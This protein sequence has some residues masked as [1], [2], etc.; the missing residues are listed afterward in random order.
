MKRL[1]RHWQL[2]NR[3]FY[4]LCC[5][6]EINYGV[7]WVTINLKPA[8][9]LSIGVGKTSWMHLKSHRT[10]WIPTE[11]LC[12]TTGYHKETPWISRKLQKVKL[13]KE[14][15]E[16]KSRIFGFSWSNVYND[17]S[18]EG[19]AI[20][21][22]YICITE[23]WFLKNVS[24]VFSQCAASLPR[25]VTQTKSLL[26]NSIVSLFMQ[27]NNV[28]PHHKVFVL[29]LLSPSCAATNPARIFFVISFI[30]FYF[31]TLLVKRHPLNRSVNSRKTHH[32]CE[33]SFTFC[34]NEGDHIASVTFWMTPHKRTQVCV[35][36]FVCQSPI[37]SLNQPSSITQT[38]VHV[39]VS[40]NFARRVPGT[41][42]G[43]TAE[44]LSGLWTEKSG[45]RASLSGFDCVHAFYFFALYLFFLFFSFHFS[46]SRWIFL[47]FF[48]WRTIPLLTYQVVLLLAEQSWCTQGQIAMAVGSNNSR[49]CGERLFFFSFQSLSLSVCADEWMNTQK[50]LPR[51]RFP[52]TS[53]AVQN[54]SSCSG[55][56]H[57]CVFKILECGSF[58]GRKKCNRGF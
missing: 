5:S 39:V 47:C 42:S 15:Y 35:C 23:G 44:K 53:L 8:Q 40:V 29:C 36:V 43:A 50:L 55:E 17:A 54:I 7:L 31:V 20:M 28:F 27:K 11:Q 41:N 49:V 32:G 58:E 52:L 25:N 51:W 46:A 30:S 4:S 16:Y 13:F 1:N 34:S 33:N 21:S 45:P 14:S 38:V 10:R 6:I 24:L 48:L 3:I 18:P 22:I 19:D 9:V 2:L 57:R 56:A 37:P 26:L 12:T